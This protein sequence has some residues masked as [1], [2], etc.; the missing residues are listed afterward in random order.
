VSAGWTSLSVDTLKLTSSSELANAFS[1]FLQGNAEIA[2]TFFGD[3]LRCAGGSLRRLYVKQASGG[4]VSA[5]QPGDLSISARSAALG[6]AIGVGGTRI[7]Q[8]YYR[9]PSLTFCPSPTGNTWNV[10]SGLQVQWLP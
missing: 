8:V 5:P 4:V 6:D 10:S 2:P 1:V 9:D 7:Y 3:G